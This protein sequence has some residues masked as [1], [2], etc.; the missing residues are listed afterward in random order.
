M[1]KSLSILVTGLILI[2]WMLLSQSIHELLTQRRRIMKRKRFMKHVFCRIWHNSAW[3]ILKSSWDRW[4]KG[5]REWPIVQRE[6]GTILVEVEIIWLEWPVILSLILSSPE[7]SEVC[8]RVLLTV[9][10]LLHDHV[11]WY[12]RNQLLLWVISL[13]YINLS[14]R[15][16]H[17]GE[18][19]TN[20]WLSFVHPVILSEWP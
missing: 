16:V 15:N 7:T 18:T 12:W 2:I 1:F 17:Q 9:L 11:R 8:M 6:Q 19:H 20:I 5:A 4:Q 3:P 10:L 13:S 14:L